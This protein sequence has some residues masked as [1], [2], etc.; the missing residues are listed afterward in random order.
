MFR[1][2]Q[3][4]Q[5]LRL[6]ATPLKRQ[7]YYFYSPNSHQYLQEDPQHTI[8]TLPE[9]IK[10]LKLSESLILLGLTNKKVH[11]TAESSGI[12]DLL[13]PYHRMMAE[14]EGHFWPNLGKLSAEAY[15]MWLEANQHRMISEIHCRAAF[16]R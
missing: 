2:T 5:S 9:R 10:T 8:A 15:T 14:I 13:V 12:H 1:A 4:V 11:D 3:L 7:I 16:D 6:T